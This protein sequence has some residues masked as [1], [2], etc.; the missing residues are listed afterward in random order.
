M[1]FLPPKSCHNTITKYRPLFDLGFKDNSNELTIFSKSVTQTLSD[2]KN[3]SFNELWN[4]VKKGELIPSIDAEEATSQLSNF[5]NLLK[6]YGLTEQEAL[7]TGNF[8][9]YFRS[10]IAS[11]TEAERTT[12]NYMQHIEKYREAQIKNGEVIEKVGIKSKLASAGM[13]ALSMAGN[14]L[15]G[16]AV[17]AGLSLAIGGVLTVI[18]E[19]IHH[20]QKLIERGEEAKKSITETYSSFDKGRS[21][22]D[23]L[24]KSFAKS[25]EEI[26]NSGDA[27]DSI[28]KKYDELHDGINSFNNENKSLSSEDYNEY[29][30]LSNQLAE[31]FPTL[32]S[33]YDSQGN[34]ILNLG[35]S[36]EEATAKIKE[37]YNA[38][39]LSANVEIGSQINDVYAGTV[40]SVDQLLSKNKE[41]KDQLNALNGISSMAINADDIYKGIDFS[42]GAEAA[43][44]EKLLVDNGLTY[45]LQEKLNENGDYVVTVTPTFDFDGSSG[46]ENIE[47]FE[48]KVQSIFN[49][50]QEDTSAQVNEIEKKIASNNMMLKDQW[51]SMIEP[52]TQFL[53]TSQSFTDM[54]QD[55]QDAITGNLDQIDLASLGDK[56][57]GDVK[58]FL[59]QEFIT[60]LS[61]LDKPMQDKLSEL[62]QIDSDSM[63]LSNYREAIENT[64]SEV[65]GSK[66]NSFFTKFGFK[67]FFED[68]GR[69]S[70]A[71]KDAVTEGKNMVNNLSGQDLDIAY[72]I[73]ANDNFSGTFAELNEKIKDAKAVAATGIDITAKTNFNAIDKADETENAGDDYVKAKKYLE[74]AKKM[75]DENLIG[76]D[77][78]KTRAAYFSPTGSNDPANFMENYAKATK[79]LTDDSSGVETFLN[80]LQSKGYA[81]FETLDDGTKK[82]SYDINDLEDAANNMGMGFEFFMDMF[83]RLEDYGFH[84]NFVGSVEQGAERITDLT[85]QLVEE[86]AKLNKME[87]TGTYTTTDE[88]GN[89]VQTVANQTALDAQR[90]KVNLLKQDILE[91][92]EA[93]D[94]LV[95]RSAEDYNAQIESAK[96]SISSMSEERQ[97]ILDENTFGDNTQAVADKMQE[98]IE[99]WASEYHL[100]L[101]ADLNVKGSDNE[102]SGVSSV[103]SDMETQLNAALENSDA[104]DQIQQYI[105]TLSEYSSEILKQIDLTDGK[106]DEING[107]DCSDAEQALEGLIS[108]LG[109]SADQ[110]HILIDAINELNNTKIESKDQT[111]PQL[112]DKTPLSDDSYEEKVQVV[113]REYSDNNGIDNA[114]LPTLTQDID[115]IINKDESE[116]TPEPQKQEVDRELKNDPTTED[117][118]DDKTFEIDADNS[119]AKEKIE[120]V[121][122]EKIADKNFSINASGNA[123]YT[124]NEIAHQLNSL[125]DKN[126]SITTTR[127]NNTI[128]KTKKEPEFTGTM[129]SPAHASGTAYNMLNLKPAYANGEISLSQDEQALVNELGK[130]LCRYKIYL[131]A[132]KPL[133]FYK[134]QRTD[135]IS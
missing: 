77:D 93:M 40:A 28:G 111:Q 116:K 57:D 92:Q 66:S 98:Q 110:V 134:L 82:W 25:E 91:T 58:S 86:Q 2:I 43:D 115:R 72:D 88:N 31:Q 41:Y 104:K 33:G 62:F 99:A 107:L 11:T 133:E 90:E 123:S 26:K 130:L 59:Y 76:T 119:K 87:K 29:L 3:F 38:Q 20:Q 125:H 9:N 126:I 118:P 45:D 131:I 127:I 63:S 97:K 94:T 14:T 51:K 56:Y 24:G 120:E 4:G 85:S 37:L 113:K 75:Y 95:A 132:E 128:N 65:F 44:F 12:Q 89:K 60:P 106:Y 36:A 21:S 10:F 103:V 50:A 5:N 15:I 1:T 42:N 19:L 129:L 74:E 79:Y 49:D 27:I 46:I 101:D 109:L 114:T 108:E 100:E 34:A 54:N 23:S 96:Q 13:T 6:D 52:I 117:S 53:N 30:E 122:K 121:K 135:E 64:F 7:D 35:N 8:T 22:L 81:T 70:S 73:V 78:F 48:A 69:L 102:D 71:I 61:E 112:A 18:D 124:I 55:I 83:G 17:S 67:K 80:D 105:D 84:N 32:V 68:K 16:M 47:D 39:Q